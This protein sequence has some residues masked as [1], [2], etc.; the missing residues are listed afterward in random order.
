MEK[1]PDIPSLEKSGAYYEEDVVW[2][3][4]KDIIED[5]KLKDFIDRIS[6]N[7]DVMLDD[8]SGE[9][10]WELVGSCCIKSPID[11]KRIIDV[12]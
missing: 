6:V 12:V 9:D 11:I 3:K 5:K 7:E 10:T 4:E 8:I 1:L 2:W